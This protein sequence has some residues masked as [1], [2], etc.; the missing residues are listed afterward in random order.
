MMKWEKSSCRVAKS[1]GFIAMQLD[2]ITALT[3]NNCVIYD[4]LFYFK[5]LYIYHLSWK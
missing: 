4:K 5:L 2:P 1:M 3:F